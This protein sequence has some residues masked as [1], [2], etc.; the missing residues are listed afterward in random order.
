MARLGL[1][2]RFARLSKTQGEQVAVVIRGAL[3]AL[4]LSVDDE[5]VRLA[6]VNQI[7]PLAGGDG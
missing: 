6:V 1:E 3:E 4:G 7:R 2:E 5:R